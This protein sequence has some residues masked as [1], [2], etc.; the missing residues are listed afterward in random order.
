MRK[1]II[2]PPTRDAAA[3]EPK[4]LELEDLVQV[5]ISSEEPEHP[6]ESALV[7]GA[8]PGWRAA[9]PGEQTIRLVFD[10]P[11]KLERIR[12]VFLETEGERT[13]EFLLR[14]SRDGGRS[15]QEIARQQ[16]NFSPSGGTQEVEDYRVELAG[17]TLLELNI[18]PDKSGGDAR[19]SLSQLR[20]A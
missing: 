12:L 16:W 14:W 20:L 7:A 17:V 19:A 18:V 4:W 1:R 2:G 11:Q 5:E 3:A 6:I 15:F 13:Q 8:G 10:R 9:Q